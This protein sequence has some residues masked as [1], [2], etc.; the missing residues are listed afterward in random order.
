[1]CFDLVIVQCIVVIV[2]LLLLF[3]VV[4]FHFLCLG[5]YFVVVFVVLGFGLSFYKRT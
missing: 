2:F 4:L 3:C 1:M 5:M